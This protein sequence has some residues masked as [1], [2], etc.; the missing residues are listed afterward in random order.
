[1]GIDSLKHR[2]DGS[3]VEGLVSLD[4]GFT[5]GFARLLDGGLVASRQRN[6]ESID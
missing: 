1:M 6:L 2:D 3:K 4:S 5:R